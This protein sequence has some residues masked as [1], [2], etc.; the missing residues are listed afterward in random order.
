MYSKDDTVLSDPEKKDNILK[1]ILKNG[2][3]SV[4]KNNKKIL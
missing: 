4:S 3:L 1:N 2:G